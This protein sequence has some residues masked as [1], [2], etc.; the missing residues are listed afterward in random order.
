MKSFGHRVSFPD[1]NEASHYTIFST[2]T[3]TT[4]HESCG[5][6]NFGRVENAP[7]NKC[8]VVDPNV[9]FG[10]PTDT[11]I[12]PV[13]MMDLH[14]PPATPL[15]KRTTQ[16]EDGNWYALDCRIVWGE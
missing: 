1:K 10:A 5:P 3:K 14:T 9:F 8:S 16:M 15:T 4:N 13:G 2:G 12:A 6:P 11:P 7:K